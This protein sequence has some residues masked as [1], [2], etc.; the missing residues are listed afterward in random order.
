M[1]K[2]RNGFTLI[3]LLV[4]VIIIGILATAAM[5]QYFKVVEKARVAEAQSI[6]AAV[7]SA[8]SRAL[9]KGGKYVKNWDELDLAFTDTKGCPCAG[10]NPCAQ[11]IYTYMLDDDGTVYAT[12]NP[13]PTPASAYGMYTLIYD[14]NTGGMTCTQANCILDLI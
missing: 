5:P 8:Q 12:R 7:K 6:F 9:A 10:M 2:I 1:K 4:V 11:R 3:E 14:I 13:T